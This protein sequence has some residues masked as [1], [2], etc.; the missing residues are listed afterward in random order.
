MRLLFIHLDIAAI[1]VKKI[2]L[3]SAIDVEDGM[4]MEKETILFVRN[5]WKK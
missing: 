4:R 3:S 1:A 2:I 5:V